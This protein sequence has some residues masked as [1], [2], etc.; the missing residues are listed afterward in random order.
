MKKEESETDTKKKILQSA[1]MVFTQKGVNGAGIKEIADR[2]EVNKAMLYYY[3]DSKEHL[4]REVFR[5]AVE[6]SGMKALEILEREDVGLFDKIRKYIELLTNR[7][8]DNPVV[9]SFVMNEVNRHPDK[10]A[11]L[12][13]DTLTFDATVLERQITEAAD[14]YEIAR[15]NPKQLLANVTALC[16]GPIVNRSYYTALLDISGEEQYRSFLNERNG[17]IYDMTISWLTS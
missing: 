4:F 11:E 9:I 3:F 13:V 16:L 2:A 15:I 12:L 5:M 6:E 14:R 10:L 7:L 8:M 17:I 1:Y